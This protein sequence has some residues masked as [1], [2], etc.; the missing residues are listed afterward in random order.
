MSGDPWNLSWFELGADR[1][2]KADLLDTSSPELDQA[3][4]EL[5]LQPVA[6]EFD[7]F[8][9]LLAPNTRVHL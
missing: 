2:D 9:C 6:S 7:R 4:D 5:L 3:G 1:V 8:D